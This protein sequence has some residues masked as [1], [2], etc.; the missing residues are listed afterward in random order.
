[1]HTRTIGRHPDATL[2]LSRVL[3]AVIAVAMTGYFSYRYLATESAEAEITAI[4]PSCEL[5]TCNWGKCGSRQRMACLGVPA[6]LASNQYVR[7]FQEARLQFVGSDGQYR[8]T[9][10]EFGKLNKGDVAVGD[11]MT[12]D[13][14]DGFGKEPEVTARPSLFMTVFG[15]GAFL[16]F[17]SIAARLHQRKW[18]GL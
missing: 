6:T 15:L 7:R 8:A 18:S 10:T 3:F 1:M 16:F 11:R 13:Y 9:W 17:L 14:F 5:V 12:I 2:T 4:R